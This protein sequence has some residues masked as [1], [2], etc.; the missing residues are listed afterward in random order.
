MHGCERSECG[1]PKHG[2]SRF[3]SFVSV[4]KFPVIFDIVD[5]VRAFGMR[6]LEW[7]V[8]RVTLVRFFVVMNE[9]V[10]NKSWFEIFGHVVWFPRMS[11]SSP[12]G[13]VRHPGALFALMCCR[14]FTVWH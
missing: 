1:F 13:H 11:M 6:G 4:V 14:I 9:N 3:I 8:V 10:H 5:I 12:N 2:P 7:T